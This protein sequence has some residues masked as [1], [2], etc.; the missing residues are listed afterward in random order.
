LNQLLTKARPHRLLIEPTGLGHP[1]EVLSTLAEYVASGVLDLRATLTLV[2]ARCVEDERYLRSDTFRQQLEVADLVIANKTDLYGTQDLEN[3]RRFL[4]FLGRDLGTSLQAVE[5]GRIQSS[6]LHAPSGFY[7]AEEHHHHTH[8]SPALVDAEP[9]PPCGYLRREN[10][11]EGYHSCG[12]RFAPMMVFDYNQLFALISGADAER[13]KG[14]FITE[15]GV[16]GFNKADAVLSVMEL[17]DTLDSRVEMID[18][19]PQDWKALESAW[20][21]AQISR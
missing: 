17:D 16:F 7:A 13:V 9:F 14:V 3:L 12:W 11:A 1:R 20:L 4:G 15:Q 19:K 21:G 2:D 5:Q 6:W 10:Q 8:H 18:Q